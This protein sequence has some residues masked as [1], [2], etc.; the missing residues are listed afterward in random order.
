MQ[1]ASS[2]ATEAPSMAASPSTAEDEEDADLLG[3][4]FSAIPDSSPALEPTSN[5]ADTVHVAIRDF[6]KAG[7]MSPRKLLEEVVRSRYVISIN[8]VFVTVLEY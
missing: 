4:M 1:P 2:T 7:G 3:G 6:G 8:I 5:G